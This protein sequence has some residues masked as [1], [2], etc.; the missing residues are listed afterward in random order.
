MVVREG[1]RERRVPVRLG[2]A[3]EARIEILEG[4]EEGDVVVGQ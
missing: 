2:I 1:D 4:L 3:T